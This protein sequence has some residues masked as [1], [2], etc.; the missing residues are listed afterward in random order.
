[1]IFDKHE[2]HENHVI[3]QENYENQNARIT[4]IKKNLEFNKRITKLIEII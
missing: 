4:K 1:M 2:N 3:Q